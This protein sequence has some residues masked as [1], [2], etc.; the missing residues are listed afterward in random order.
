MTLLVGDLF[1]GAAADLTSPTSVVLGC[2][3][4]VA[5]SRSVT[6]SADD[7]YSVAGTTTA[8]GCV[9]IRAPSMPDVCGAMVDVL[10]VMT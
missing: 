9:M 4:A 3:G 6:I 7:G 10:E 1:Y 8:S 2:N 5:V